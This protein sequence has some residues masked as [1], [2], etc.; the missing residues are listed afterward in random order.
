MKR[1]EDLAQ[2]HQHC[3]ALHVWSVWQLSLVVRASRTRL[4]SAMEEEMTETECAA[5][6]VGP[7]RLLCRTI[8]LFIWT[9]TGSSTRTGGCLILLRNNQHLHHAEI[10]KAQGC[11]QSVAGVLS[12]VTTVMLLYL[13]YSTTPHSSVWLILTAN[14]VQQGESQ[15]TT[16]QTGN[17][18]SSESRAGQDRDM[19]HSDY[20]DYGWLVRTLVISKERSP[21]R[22]GHQQTGPACLAMSDT[23][24]CDIEDNDGDAWDRMQ[25][26]ASAGMHQWRPSSVLYLVEPGNTFDD[27]I[28]RWLGLRWSPGRF[29]QIDYWVV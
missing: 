17:V 11:Y 25:H 2:H 1:D 29:Q 28:W 22:Q 6:Y 8:W 9:Q 21:Q 5:V 3:P 13:T 4:R 24:S 10:R 7:A 27:D 16:G 12:S 15:R 18:R 23:S 26:S 14:T 20:S 19:N